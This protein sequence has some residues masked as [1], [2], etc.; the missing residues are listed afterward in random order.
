MTLHDRVTLEILRPAA[1]GDCIAHH[2]GRTVF[3]TGA[4]P[5]E[6][7]DAR[8][9]GESRRV[10]RAAT[11]RV[12]E[13]SPH[14]ITDRR[15]EWGA[16]GAG[17]IEFAHVE[18]AHSRRLKEQ[19]ARDQLIR[20]GGID[21]DGV[22]FRVLPAPTDDVE[23]DSAGTRWR[24][25]VQCA[26]DASGRL[27]ML[28]A[29]SHT[30]V[31]F[32][33]GMIPLAVEELNALGLTGERLPGI[34]RVEAAIGHESGA[35]VLRGPGAKDHADP[36]IRRSQGWPGEWSI[37]VEGAAAGAAAPGDVS[38]GTRSGASRGGASR[39]GA[40]KGSD[41]HRARGRAGRGARNRGGTSA[42]PLM[43]VAG[44]GLVRER[45]PGLDSDLRVRGQGFWQ[46]HRDAAGVLAGAVRRAV[47]D[48]GGGR[49]LDLYSGAGLLGIGLAQD[50]HRVTG[51]EGSAEAVA[52]ARANAAGL[53]A[54]FDV[55]RV[56]DA[57]LFP[58][59]R[60]AVLDPP[61]SGAGPAVVDS[62]LSSPV[63]RIVHVSCDGA[64]LARDLRTL[65]AGG[66][67]VSSV[68][69]HDLFPLTGHL[70]FLAVLDR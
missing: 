47:G 11:E 9:T 50:G 49:V 5:G 29:S 59:A 44:D 21:A 15:L 31:P 37:L 23:A 36:F 33:R 16:P 68:V 64:T 60:V 12:H 24:T 17:G 38:A 1:G 41:R 27:G 10:L 63:E 18:L 25:R 51:L 6:T 45:V 66:F 53:D 35:V 48:P 57:A 34:S 43:L 69:A 7:V 40:S 28:A 13:P 54:Q 65:I 62:L 58:D 19:A 52:D 32:E 30:V 70:E 61:R 4:L 26:V 39:R 67:H 2:D 3:V 20:I 55:G 22:G 8:I 46:V 14:R 56:E 42:G